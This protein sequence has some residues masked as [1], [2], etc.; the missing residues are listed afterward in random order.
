M[1]Y[2]YDESLCLACG[3]HPGESTENYTERRQVRTAQV[4]PE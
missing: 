2:R 4:Q 3:W 1:A